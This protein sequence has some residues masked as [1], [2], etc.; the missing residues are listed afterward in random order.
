MDVLVLDTDFSNIG[1]I[2]TYTSLIWTVRYFE[3]GDFELYLPAQDPEMSMLKINY[4]LCRRNDMEVTENGV[5]YRNVMIVEK[6]QIKSDAENGNYL[7]VS[8]R[9]LKSILGRRIIWTQTTISGNIETGIRRLVTEN[10]ISPSIEERKIDNLVLGDLA[11]ITG[12]TETQYTGKNLQDV[13]ESLC[14]S[15]GCG[16]DID[17]YNGEFIFYLYVGADRSYNQTENPYVVFSQDYDN[18]LSTDYSLDFQKFKNAALVAGE[19]EGTARK[20]RAVG[21]ASGLGRY[22]LYVDSR[23]TSTNNEEYTEEEYNNILIGR[24]TEKLA[25]YQY[26][27]SFEGEIEIG[28]TYELGKDYF[29]GDIVQV[30]NEFGIESATRILEIIESDSDEGYSAI[31]TFGSLEV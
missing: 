4:Y 26:K 25:E 5:R 30:E 9:S 12:T 3:S 23:D 14:Q 15:C 24:G 6:I 11:G 17:I 29:L 20:T 22:E 27:E 2:D 28:V 8:G 7:I 10:A 16:Y 13:V 31:P 1:I 21:T 18:L 19:G